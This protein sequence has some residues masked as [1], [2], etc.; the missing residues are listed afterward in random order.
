M[1]VSRQDASIEPDGSDL[2][3]TSTFSTHD[4]ADFGGEPTEA[5]FVGL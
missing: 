5:W 3:S 1:W 2:E 4:Y